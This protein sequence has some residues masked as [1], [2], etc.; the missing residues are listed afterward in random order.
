[1][2][3]RCSSPCCT[4]GAA[5]VVVSEVTPDARPTHVRNQ[6]AN[7]PDQDEPT[8]DREH[9]A[10]LFQQ[11][12]HLR[13]SQPHV[14][15]AEPVSEGFKMTDEDLQSVRT[16]VPPTEASMDRASL[17]SLELLSSGALSSLV[18]ETL[19]SMA[20]LDAGYQAQPSGQAESPTLM[21]PAAAVSSRQV[22]K[23]D[24]DPCQAGLGQSESPA[25]WS[26]ALPETEDMPEVA[27]E[28][29]G[30]PNL[31][32]FA[33]KWCV[34]RIDGEYGRFMADTGASP[35]PGSESF[36]YGMGMRIQTITHEG[37]DITIRNEGSNRAMSF[38]V[39]AGP[40]KTVG[41][42][43][44]HVITCARWEDDVIVMEF[45][46]DP[47]RDLERDPSRETHRSACRPPL[48]TFRRYLRGEQ[49]VVQVNVSEDRTA[50]RFFTKRR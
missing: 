35:R 41:L 1:M 31:P 42:D 30:R 17:S 36:D 19:C 2:G 38:R 14:P 5:T 21:L 11:A 48:K 49:M 9:A 20:E 26:P 50:R 12:S 24:F 15:L 46:R 3:A 37:D 22:V 13:E 33:G 28:S 45:R 44:E 40:M 16:S 43:G 47:A 34:S 25:P 39:G 32:N 7:Q 29:R 10:S 4:H 27:A 8:K 18:D 6:E 23:L